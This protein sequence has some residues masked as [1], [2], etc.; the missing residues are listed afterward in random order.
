MLSWDVN[1]VSVECTD[2]QGNEEDVTISEGVQHLT[3]EV[4]SKDDHEAEEKG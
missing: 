2:D 1:P 4:Y 3:E